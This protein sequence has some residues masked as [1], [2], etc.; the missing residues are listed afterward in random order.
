MPILF[1]PIDSTYGNPPM[2]L[3][4]E[5]WTKERLLFSCES[6]SRSS[7][8]PLLDRLHPR[9]PHQWTS[10]QTS[11]R[12]I[13]MGCFYYETC[14][15]RHATS[16]Y[17]NSR[18]L[19]KHSPNIPRRSKGHR[20][21]QSARIVFSRYEPCMGRALAAG[22]SSPA[23]PWWYPIYLLHSPCPRTPPDFPLNTF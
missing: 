11:S 18:T 16:P 5:S 19:W 7:L 3:C 6:S 14:I 9:K 12:L 15:N 23:P 4:A 20:S 10:I 17:I 13:S 1:L 8:L 21:A 2:V 22:K